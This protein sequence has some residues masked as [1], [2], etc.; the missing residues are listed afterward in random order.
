MGGY[1]DNKKMEVNKID[2][3]VG[4]VYQCRFRLLDR[5]FLA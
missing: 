1:R 4:K 2:L 5:G 3:K